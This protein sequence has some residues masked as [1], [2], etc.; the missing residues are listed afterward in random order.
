MGLDEKGPVDVGCRC[1][2]ARVEALH[3]SHLDQQPLVLGS[4]EDALGTVRIRGEGFFDQD[5]YASVQRLQSHHLMR[6]GRD[7]DYDPLTRLQKGLQRVVPPDAELAGDLIGSGCV[8]VEDSRGPRP[9]QVAGDARVVAA[10]TAD[11]D[12]TDRRF[13]HRGDDATEAL[14]PRAVRTHGTA[15]RLPRG[16]IRR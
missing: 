2:E 9:L 5:V 15:L 14:R 16:S 7:G 11:T 12:D 6:F 13:L 1:A 8:D 4:V 10:Q 3:V